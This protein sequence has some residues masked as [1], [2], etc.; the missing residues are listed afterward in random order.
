MNLILYPL[1]ILN[2][3]NAPGAAQ[4][5]LKIWIAITADKQAM[6]ELL[7]LSI[8]MNDLP[9]SIRL[10][11]R[12]LEQDPQNT[13]LIRNLAIFNLN[14]G[15]TET[16]AALFTEHMRLTTGK[17]PILRVYRNALMDQDKANRG[18]P[19]VTTL[20]DVLVDTE[21]W[22]ILDSDRVYARETHGRTI[23][24]GQFVY[25]RM[26]PDGNEFIYA[27]P[28]NIQHIDTPCIF[29]GGDDNYSHWLTRNLIKLV[30]LEDHP[31]TD[32]LPFLINEDLRS[33]QREYLELLGIP[34]SRLIKVPRNAIIHCQQ[35]V[36]P[37]ILRGHPDMHKGINWL[38]G[39][40]SS[41]IAAPE[42]ANDLVYLSRRDTA[43][44]SLVNDIELADALGELGFSTVVTGELSVKDQIN[45]MSKAKVIV[46]AHGAGMTN[47]IF[48][49]PGAIIIEITSTNIAHMND[50]R[51]IAQQLKQQI[52]TLVSSDITASPDP[53][54]LELNY[55]YRISI[56]E[57]M[58]ALQ[59]LCPELFASVNT[60]SHQ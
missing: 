21:Y 12:L 32:N 26:T 4:R 56:P 11:E 39:R 43:L 16:A 33:Y 31:A 15:K 50:F 14:L 57:V 9:E 37:T 18:I 29:L 38:R 13:M 2:R 17:T 28:D 27:I 25:G 1:K 30:L 49:P 54:K 8:A 23:V 34:E 6:H 60:T 22:S 58:Q 3:M 53:D 59:T 52:K 7:A 47:I 36:V 44:R 45:A 48:A 40:L 42:E 55:D 51:F 35:L 41:L 24:N 10:S 5:L 46:A 20:N 19:Y